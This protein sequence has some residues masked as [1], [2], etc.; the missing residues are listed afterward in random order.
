MSI[1]NIWCCMKNNFVLTK[2]CWSCTK[3]YFMS[4]KKKL[5]QHKKVF[6]VD[7]NKMMLHQKNILCAKKLFFSG[8][9]PHIFLFKRFQINQK[10]IYINLCTQRI[11]FEINTLRFVWLRN[12]QQAISRSSLIQ[13]P[14]NLTGNNVSLF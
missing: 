5:M 11:Y 9:A 12:T 6:H 13:T 2:T 14:P 4:S 7:E 8:T 10:F 3:K 1:T